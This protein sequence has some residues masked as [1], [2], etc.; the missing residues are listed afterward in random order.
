MD[1]K[2]V[3]F[4]PFY[5][6]NQFMLD[7]FRVNVIHEVLSSMDKI[8]AN[9]RKDLLGQIKK[10]IKIPGFRNCLQAPLSVKTHAM[11]QQFERNPDLV[12]DTLA[13]WADIHADLRQTVFD[14]LKGR[15][16]ELLPIDAN[17]TKLPGF[18]TTWDKDETFE[19]LDEAYAVFAPNNTA[20]SDEA[21]LM[22]VWLSMRLP[23]EM[24]D[25]AAKKD[26]EVKAEQ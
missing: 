6:I 16:W 19:A 4:M 17:R 21:R 23:Y 12:V 24:V 25:V 11:I 7:E 5:A 18:L 3:K 20:T 9:L 26:D 1:D 14:F 10:L 15:N 2:Q 22:V 13:A 8:D